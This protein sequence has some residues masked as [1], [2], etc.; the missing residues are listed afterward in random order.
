MNWKKST[1]LTAA[2]LALAAALGAQTSR[3][4]ITGTVLDPTGAVIRGARVT[5]TGVETGV[6]LSTDS[7]DAGAYRFEAVDLGVYE[8]QVSHPGFRTN[9]ATGIGVEANRATTV[10][11]KLEVGA[12]ETR[13]EVSGE[14]SDILITDSP[15]SGFVGAGSSR[16]QRGIH[17][18]QFRPGQKGGSKVGKTK[19]GKGT[20]IMAVAD[21]HG[22]PVGLAIESA[23][24]HEVKLVA[25]TLVE[26]VIAEASQ[27][28][29][30][31]NAYDSETGRGT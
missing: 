12:A 15:R 20:K 19:R 24:P 14:S 23:S 27:N 29:V 30:G 9:V 13:I 16:C 4:T 1:K 8:L 10:D 17:R 22:L 26:M 5:L 31:D 7:N 25:S 6:R 21:S 28:L 18:W 11:P 2:A 3:G